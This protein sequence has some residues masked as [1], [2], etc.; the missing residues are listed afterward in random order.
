MLYTT[1]RNPFMH[2]FTRP[3]CRKQ[4]LVS[5]WK[6]WWN[7]VGNQKKKKKKNLRAISIWND[8]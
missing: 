4:W 8:Y 3:T 5:G 7:I 2:N 6:F 1:K